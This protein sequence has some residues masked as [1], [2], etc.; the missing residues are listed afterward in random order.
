MSIYT[1]DTDPCLPNP[2]PYNL[3]CSSNSSMCCLMCQCSCQNGGTCQFLNNNSTCLCSAGFTGNNCETNVCNPSP[4][5]NNGLCSV[6]GNAFTCLCL[7]GFSGATCQTTEVT[8]MTTITT[9]TTTTTTTASNCK[10]FPGKDATCVYFSAP[11][12]G[13]CSNPLSFLN[14]TVFSVACKKS[15]KLC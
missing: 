11:T 13:F 10:N 6:N 4:C 12:F 2:C 14:G 15:C 3:M 9:T 7:P 1:Q 5:Q 8:T